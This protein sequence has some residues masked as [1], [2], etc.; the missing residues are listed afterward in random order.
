M[1]R[2]RELCEKVR[3]CKKVRYPAISV[4]VPVY[5]GEKRIP[6][7]LTS[8]FKSAAEYSNFCEI[9]VVD[10]GS[11]DYT[12][13]IA[14]ATIRKW[15]RRLPNIKG[16]VIK[17][18]SPL[19]KVEAVRMGVDGAFGELIIVV[20]SNILLKPNALKEI[21]KAYYTSEYGREIG[22]AVKV[23]PNPWFSRTATP[24]KTF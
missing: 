19:G 6:E 15:R 7:F 17:S 8:L 14:W 10:D 1:Q 4:I 3:L 18:F 16:R 12:Y 20:N 9:M 24:L 23:F 2:R 11:S 13:E 21:A 5:N 22:K